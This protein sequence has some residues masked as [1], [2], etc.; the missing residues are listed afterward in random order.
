MPFLITKDEI[1]AGC[2]KQRYQPEIDAPSYVEGEEYEAVSGSAKE[3]ESPATPIEVAEA[4]KDI[5]DPEIPVNI[6]D[7]GLIYDVNIG[8]SGDTVV[9]MTL[10]APNCPAAGILPK[11]VADCAAGVPGVARVGV[12]LTFDVPWN[13]DMMSEIAE[14]E[15]GM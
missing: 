11:E 1:S 4:F 6:Y 14:V 3:I 9:L 10:T 2:T 12:K 13:P 15:L 8:R 7:L 5:F